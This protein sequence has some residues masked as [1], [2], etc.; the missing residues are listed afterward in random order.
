M[1]IYYYL[2]A[3]ER[4]FALFYVI[5]PIA[6]HS[7]YLADPVLETLARPCSFVA[8]LLSPKSSRYRVRGIAVAERVG[9]GEVSEITS[10]RALSKRRG[11]RTVINEDE[12]LYIIIYTWIYAR[13]F[14]M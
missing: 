7:S 4:P 11:N 14:N 2:R 9:G 6:A 3:L 10:S 1:L 12:W 13:G 5:L 8:A